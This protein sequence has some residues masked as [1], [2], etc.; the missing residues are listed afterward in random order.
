MARPKA[1]LELGQ[2]YEFVSVRLKQGCASLEHRCEGEVDVLEL[3]L[4]GSGTAEQFRKSQVY[5]TFSCFIAHGW[6]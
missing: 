4:V 6:R 5:M 1:A 3:L 2:A